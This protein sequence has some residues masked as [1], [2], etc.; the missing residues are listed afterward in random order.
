[1][2]ANGSIF[3][4]PRTDKKT[5]T[6]NNSKYPSVLAMGKKDA[7]IVAA[8]YLLLANKYNTM[9]RSMALVG[10]VKKEWVLD[11]TTGCQQNNN[12]ASQGFLNP[13]RL[14]VR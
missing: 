7:T 5:K 1:M 2:K 8:I 14:A 12:N 3:H 6:T 10:S 13:I 11:K 4:F 9:A